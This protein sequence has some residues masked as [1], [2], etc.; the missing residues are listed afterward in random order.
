[1]CESPMKSSALTKVVVESIEID[2][3]FVCEIAREAGK[4]ILE[5]LSK[6]SKELS[7]KISNADLVTETDVAVEKHVI[8]RIIKKYTTH[9][10]FCEESVEAEQRLTDEPTWIIDP[11][12]GTTNF[13]HGVPLCCVSIGFAVN[14]TPQC[15]VV[16]NPGSNEMFVAAKGHGAYLNDVK[17]TTSGCTDRTRALVTTGMSVSLA[18]RLN[19]PN[20][21]SDERNA[22]EEHMGHV[23]YNIKA[24]VTQCQDIRRFGS[25]AQDLC[26]LACGRVDGVC[27][28]TP[29]EWD[30]CAAWV[31]V[32]EAGGVIVDYDNTALDISCHRC[33]GAASAELGEQIATLLSFPKNKRW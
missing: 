32:E 31:I 19:N 30:I 9:R 3:D 4:M 13:V 1:M 22:I 16:F 11:I 17:I 6:R 20:L 29:K 27:E 28:M 10:F 15:G 21:D 18:H 14:K 2:V 26:Y 12:D 8:Q 7:F 25:I 5:N 33:L 24:I 23:W